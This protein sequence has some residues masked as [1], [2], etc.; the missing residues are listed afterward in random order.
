MFTDASKK[1]GLGPRQN[2]LAA[3]ARGCVSL[4]LAFSLSA[5]VVLPQTREVYDPECQQTTRQITLEVAQLR[6]FQ[7]CYGDGCVVLLVAAS[8]VTLAS[9][10]VSSSI[11]VVGNI[12]YWKERRGSCSRLPGPVPTPASEP[13]VGSQTGP[14]TRPQTGPT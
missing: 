6:G 1:P 8:A 13:Q 14:Q 9:L 10:V 12:V 3:A 11:A 7:H 5:C 2:R 4:V